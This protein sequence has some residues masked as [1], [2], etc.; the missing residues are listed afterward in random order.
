V[1]K[2]WQ[3]LLP[4]EVEVRPIELPNRGDRLHEKPLHDMWTLAA[5][6]TEVLGDELDQPFAL[7]GHSAGALMAYVWCQH[8]R[9]VGKPLPRH[10]FAA[11]FSAPGKAVNPV[12]RDMLTVYRQHGLERMPSLDDICQP[13]AEPLIGKLIDALEFSMKQARLFN[14]SRELIHAQLPSLVATF[15]M[16]DRFQPGTPLPLAL[17]ISGLHGLGDIQV[18]EGDVRAWQHLSTTGF[19]FKAFEGNH[20]FIEPG[21]SVN[22][23]TAY[24]G[25]VLQDIVDNDLEPPLFTP[26]TCLPSPDIAAALHDSGKIGA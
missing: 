9:A 22:Q 6:L 14:F 5:T 25:Q 1:F 18:L 12:I 7:Y 15:E 11:A 10:L 20:L 19:T 24:V 2:E 23:V 13:G 4:D 26:E 16:V 17:P 21:Q 3:A 8:L